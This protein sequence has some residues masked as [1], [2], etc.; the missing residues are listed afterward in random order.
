MGDKIWNENEREVAFLPEI[1]E[2]QGTSG[3]ANLLAK[4]LTAAFNVASEFAWS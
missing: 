1:V 3:G 4:H 2:R